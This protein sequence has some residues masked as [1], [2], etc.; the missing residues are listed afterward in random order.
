[1]RKIFLIGFCAGLLSVPVCGQIDGEPG[2]QPAE[3][4]TKG[5][6][7][8]PLQD[9]RDRIYYPGDTESFKPLITKLGGNLLLDQKQIWTSPLHMRKR[10]AKWWIGFGAATA[11][12]VAT[13]HRTINTFENSPGQ[14]TWAGR[15][16]NIGSEY[17]LVR[18]LRDF[19]ATA[20]GSK[21]L[22]PGRWVSWAP[23]R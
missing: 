19:M 11:A 7:P 5:S 10:D 6:L 21:T 17:T 23:N 22:K 18:W 9:P 13:D 15:Y 14:I 16:S 2:N 4:E 1:M 12:L 3:D 8:N 20:C